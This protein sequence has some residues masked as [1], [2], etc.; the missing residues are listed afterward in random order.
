MSQHAHACK[1]KLRLPFD[2]TS[3][4]PAVHVLVVVEV[5]QQLNVVCSAR[6]SVYIAASILTGSSI[7]LKQP[8][9]VEL[10]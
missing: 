4:E 7:L 2:L 6:Y 10:W 8:H 1:R 3:Q 5:L 9:M